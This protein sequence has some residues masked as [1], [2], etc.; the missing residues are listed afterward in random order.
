MDAVIEAIGEYVK[1][2]LQANKPLIA[3]GIL[4]DP[5]A[6]FEEHIK[7]I[8]TS[9]KLLNDSVFNSVYCCGYENVYWNEV[10]TTLEVYFCNEID[11]AL[12]EKEKE[13]DEESE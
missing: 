13:D 3:K 5:E 4:N 2:A 6:W 11:E 10:S 12:Y 1:D 8:H 7:N 9:K